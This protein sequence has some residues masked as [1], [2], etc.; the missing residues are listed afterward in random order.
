MK[1]KR[2]LLN[3][4][5]EISEYHEQKKYKKEAVTM[6]DPLSNTLPKSKKNN[7]MVVSNQKKTNETKSK[8]FSQF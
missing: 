3:F 4:K 8:T 6:D 5:M 7:V 1:T 2:I